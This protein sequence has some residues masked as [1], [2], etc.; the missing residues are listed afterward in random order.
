MESADDVVGKSVPFEGN[1]GLSQINI[2]D[3]MNVI[4]GLKFTMVSPGTV[5]D[6]DY[7]DIKIGL[8]TNKDV[9]TGFCHFLECMLGKSERTGSIFTTILKNILCLL[10]QDFVILKITQPLIGYI[11]CLLSNQKSYYF[12]YM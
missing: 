11:P 8:E 10:L 6:V 2:A 3:W 4:S 7:V 9:L 12:Q 1:T 5:R